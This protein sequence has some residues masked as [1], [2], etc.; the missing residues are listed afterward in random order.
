M[1]QLF[2]SLGGGGVREWKSNAGPGA[3][4]L[5]WKVGHLGTPASL[6]DPGP[7]FPT[8]TEARSL[9]L[10]G[11]QGPPILRLEAAGSIRGP[12]REVRKACPPPRRQVHPSPCVQEYAGSPKRAGAG[13]RV[14]RTPQALA[15]PRGRAPTT[16]PGARPSQP[17]LPFP[18]SPGRGRPPREL[19][20]APTSK[21][22]MARA[23]SSSSAG[24]PSSSGSTPIFT[25]GQPQSSC[26]TVS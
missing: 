7:S 25:G 8:W 15:G 16:A 2:C 21:G 20:A 6:L 9:R 14:P 10:K 11:R 19:P 18:P 4:R 22:S 17:S 12:P 13:G 24:P 1:P 3:T 26:C 5:G 23:A